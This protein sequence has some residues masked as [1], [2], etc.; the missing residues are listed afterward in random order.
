M[1]RRVTVILTGITLFG[2]AIAAPGVSGGA[3][4]KLL[5]AGALQHALSELLPQF[6]KDTGHVVSAS[7]GPVGALAD[8]L[9]KG[10]AAD[11]AIVSDTQ[12]DELQTS[13]KVVG[14]TRVDIARTGV[15]AF[16]RKNT[17]KPDIGS[18]DAFKRTLLAAKAVTYADPASGGAA[19]NYIAQL[20]D[21]LGI[22]AEINMK[23]KL[24]PRGGSLMYQL[25]ANGEADLGFDQISI[26]LVQPSVEFVGPLPEQIQH[27]TTFA[28]GVGTTRSSDAG[29]A[30]IAFLAAPHAQARMKG[31]GFDVGKD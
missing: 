5:A 16:V 19:G 25:V 28:A 13:G 30:L 21:R 12:I 1:N 2:F 17:Q 31:N 24:D 20:V 23:K 18:V 3:E 4:I 6:E 15:G 26:I 14:G 8:R 9:A 10:E 27:Y 7:Y 22:S 29:R 11:V